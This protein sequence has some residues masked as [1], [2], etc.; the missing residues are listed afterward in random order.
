MPDILPTIDNEP[1][2]GIQALLDTV[3]LW[4]QDVANDLIEKVNELL[5]EL[6]DLT[7]SGEIKPYSE[8]TVPVRQYLPMYYEDGVYVAAQEIDT[9]P[10]QPDMSKWIL[11]ATKGSA[12]VAGNGIDIDGD[13]ISVEQAVIQGASA[14]STAVQPAGMTSAISSHNT[15]VDA[16]ANLISPIASSVSG[17]EAKIPS[18]ASSSNQLA[19]KNFVNSSIATNTAN[20]IGTFNSVAE[21]EA[22]SGPV[23]NNDY[24]YVI[25][26][27]AAGNTLYDRYKYT[28]ATTPA[29]WGYEYTLNNSSFTADQ[30]AAI[31]SHA[32]AAS[33]SQISTNQQNISGIQT[34]IGSFGDIV[35]HNVNEFAT[36]SQGA[37]ADTAVQPGDL[38]T[39]A[40]TGDYEDLINKPVIPTP[41]IPQYETMPTAGASN[42][43]E[44]AQYSGVTIPE[45]EESATITQTVG[46][47]L[48]DLSVVLD[49]FVA[50]EQPS[51]DEVVSFVAR[52]ESDGISP[53]SYSEGGFEFVIDPTTFIAWV[54]NQLSSTTYNS[55]AG[56]D[57]TARVGF[58]SAWRIQGYDS[59]RNYITDGDIDATDPSSGITVSQYGSSADVVFDITVIR[60]GP[61]DWLKNGATVD[62]A[63]YGITYTG[64]PANGDTLTVDYTAFV[65]GIT[66]G[67][68][69]K[70]SAEY[71]DPSATI[72]QTVGS[73]LTD[74]SVDV[75]TFVET[76]QPSGS[77]TVN[78]VAGEAQESLSPTVFSAGGATFSFDA[79][80][81][82]AA[83]RTNMSIVDMSQ[84]ALLQVTTTSQTQAL[85]SAY[86]ENSSVLGSSYYFINQ[87]ESDWGLTIDGT[88]VFDV[89]QDLN[90]NYTPAGVVWLLNGVSA[91]LAEYGISYSGTP[92]N[93]DT[94]TVAYT[95]PAPIGYYWKQTDVQPSS[96]GGN[97]GIEWKTKVDLP[98][99]YI[100]DQWQARPYYT[101]T[102][103]LPDGTY[104]FYFS[105]KTT[106]EADGPLG[107]VIFKVLVTIDNTNSSFNGKMGYVFNGDYMNDSNYVFGD[108]LK[109]MYSLVFKHG[110]DTILFC[111][112]YPWAS[113]V[114][115]YITPR[116]VP[117]C[118][119][120]S[121]I[122][123]VDTGNEYVATGAINLDGS[124]PEYTTQYGGSV[125][126]A[127]LVNQ[128][129][130]P[131][132]TAWTT[133]MAADFATKTVYINK[134][135]MGGSVHLITDGSELII[136][137]GGIGGNEIT[138][139]SQEIVRATG[140]FAECY[141]AYSANY[142]YVMG[143]DT[144]TAATLT[145]AVR[146]A[147]GGLTNDGADIWFDTIPA[148]S[149][150]LLA[151]F[152]P[153]AYRLGTITYDGLGNIVQYTGETNANYTNGYFYKATGTVVTVPASISFINVNPS[154]VTV[155]VADPDALVTALNNVGS[156]GE[157]WVRDRL[158]LDYTDFRI[159]YNFD[160]GT[161]VR[162]WWSSYGDIYAQD[163]LD[164]FAI[165][166]TGSYTGEVSIS[167]ACNHGYA[168]ESKDVQNPAWAR[169]DVQS[170]GG[171]V[172]SVNGQTG[173][174][175]LGAADV[176]AVPLA[177]GTMTGN[178]TMG[179]GTQINVTSEYT[180]SGY[181][182]TKILNVSGAFKFVGDNDSETG[183]VMGVGHD[184][185]DGRFMWQGLYPINTSLFSATLGT[186]NHKWQRVFVTNINNGAD[187]AV[188]T[189]GGTMVVAVPPTTPNTTWVLKATVD[190]NGVCTVAWVQEV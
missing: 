136:N 106:T 163:V 47:G 150:T 160:T 15:S 178:L 175:V 161:I 17:I 60:A 11:I 151:Q 59:N 162:V 4:N 188:P 9:L 37:K 39:V 2:Q 51:G 143:V 80:T 61:A 31:N 67:Y 87:L 182:E 169:V 156:W 41:G 120:L 62:L 16:H 172:S 70:S 115:G 153:Q 44:I 25:R 57:L 6:Q 119:K 146:C 90:M 139:Y 135:I 20:F 177:G 116:L 121:A 18:Q 101:I 7:A 157:Q 19:D 32:T 27:D 167:F 42:L 63:N 112:E 33:I 85:I 110:N 12:F 75:D 34:T 171:A 68:F 124:W 145:G 77:E 3:Y 56:F 91:D 104:E 155:T 107:E 21:L 141:L 158:A 113:D 173:A 168:P 166:T 134:R 30:W 38:A 66:N 170:G 23:T 79:D 179:T 122:K 69:Y 65:A 14:G 183:I 10:S 126:L 98:A 93:G 94:L 49:A 36:A 133:L 43:G 78:F 81:F 95:A 152:G 189:T 149:P 73:G 105:T 131:T 72:S 26:T 84:V 82:L 187:I 127:S 148:E 114:F 181:L 190:A 184:S 137:L 48:T 24:A 50:E 100:G 13:V 55:V 52:V 118:F 132:S 154:D 159:D 8:L 92:A 185:L 102:G 180:S 58:P 89:I 46:S 29:S 130:I 117:E 108:I 86:D 40:T 147:C 22:Y 28:E 71:S 109:Q 99:E 125:R 174:V 111:S 5:E 186:T 142:T 144:T 64:A 54:R 176:N 103:G 35:T 53:T 74:L 88:F 97:A 164:C 128:P 83:V 76:E 1:A 140:I 123:N 165:S 45:V 138:P 129:H 96:G